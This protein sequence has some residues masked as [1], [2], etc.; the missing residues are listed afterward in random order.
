MEMPAFI[1]IIDV[2]SPVKMIKGEYLQGA[3][4]PCPAEISFDLIGRPIVN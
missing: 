4:V 2:H 1:T 3:G